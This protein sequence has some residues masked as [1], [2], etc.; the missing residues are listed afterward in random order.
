MIIFINYNVYITLYESSYQYEYLIF[1]D[2]N[3]YITNTK[4]N[5]HIYY[6]NMIMINNNKN[7]D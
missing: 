5:K 7:C 4:K 6:N 2:N 3:I 1:Y